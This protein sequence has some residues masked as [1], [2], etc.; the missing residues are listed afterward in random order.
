[1]LYTPP[2]RTLLTLD[3]TELQPQQAAATVAGGRRPTSWVVTNY[4]PS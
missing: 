2:D 3:T 4:A 1:M